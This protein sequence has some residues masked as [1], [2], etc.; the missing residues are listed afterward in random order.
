MLEI[1]SIFI[2]TTLSTDGN[3]AD[4]FEEESDSKNGDK[5]KTQWVCRGL[6]IAM[7]IKAHHH[8]DRFSQ[9][10]ISKQIQ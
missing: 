1:K 10:A 3:Y 4:D 5:N 2:L 9:E 6:C 8:G 7:V